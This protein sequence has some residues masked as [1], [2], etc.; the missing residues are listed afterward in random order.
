MQKVHTSEIVI[1]YP[2]PGKQPREMPFYDAKG[3]FDDD[4]RAALGL[5]NVISAKHANV[6]IRSLHGH[7]IDMCWQ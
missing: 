1:T 3:V 6:G 7:S 2:E 5:V 4:A